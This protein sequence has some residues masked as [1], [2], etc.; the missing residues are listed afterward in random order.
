MKLGEYTLKEGVLAPGLHKKSADINRMFANPDIPTLMSNHGCVFAN[1]VLPYQDY[2][3]IRTHPKI[4]KGISDVS[5]LHLSIYTQTCLVPFHGT[6][7]M[8]YFGMQP[9]NTIG[10][11]FYTG[12]RMGKSARSEKK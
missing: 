12:W 2:V 6:I 10:R 4:L 9:R 1:A 7:G 8:F 3:R 5:T 11:S